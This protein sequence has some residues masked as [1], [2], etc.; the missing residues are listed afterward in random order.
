MAFA[1]N[2][3]SEAAFA[4]ESAG[5]TNVV[6]TGFGLTANSGTVT[7]AGTIGVDVPVT[8]FDL[9]VNVTT[10]IQDT[11][12]AFAE[13]PFAT[14]SPSTFS[15]P[16]VTVGIVSNAAVTGIAMTA[17]LGTAITG[18]DANV[19]ATGL[20]LTAALGTAVGFGLTTA[21]VTGLPMTATLGTVLPS[22]DV[23]TE[24][25]TGIAMSAS[26]GSVTA[27][28]NSLIVPTG[29]AM[30]MNE[31]TATTTADAN[32]TPTGIAM[33]ASLG[34]VGIALNTPV[35]LTGNLLTMQE[36]TATAT[37]SL[38]IL[39]GIQ[40]TMAQGSVVGP[41]IWNPVPTGN[42]PLDPPGWKEVA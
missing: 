12:F 22:T 3:F 37:D 26:L 29:I 7:I 28:P 16:N 33:S 25:V 41:I 36:G 35:D 31:G 34:S 30:T 27:T 10:E 19:T 1:N 8:G 17:S 9:T 14:Q 11:L 23:V 15:P 5:I 20:P 38:A 39:T 24:D 40:M 2:T 6:P 42:A 21:A 32:I 18:A 4:S 13:A